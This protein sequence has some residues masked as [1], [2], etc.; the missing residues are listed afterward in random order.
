MIST[1]G[2][3]SLFPYIE[4]EE[5][6]ITRITP[7]SFAASEGFSMPRIFTSLEVIGSLIEH[8]TEGKDP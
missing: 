4:D 3:V 8:G 6:V 1:L 7:I 5:A 2:K